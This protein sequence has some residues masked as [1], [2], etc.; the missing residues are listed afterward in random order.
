MPPVLS[1]L[2]SAVQQRQNRKRKGWGSHGLTGNC[3]SQGRKRSQ[4]VLRGPDSAP[5][6]ICSLIHMV[7]LV[8]R[9]YTLRFGTLAQAFSHEN[10][11]ARIH[12]PSTSQANG[13]PGSPWRRQR[14]RLCWDQRTYDAHSLRE[15]FLL[16]LTS[17]GPL[18]SQ[19][20]TTHMNCSQ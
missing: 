6:L 20:E 12:L 18:A 5:R 16:E 7:Y 3:S 13:P 17:W 8:M 4:D 9:V 15:S 14:R 10:T 11:P 19:L 1:H 2:P